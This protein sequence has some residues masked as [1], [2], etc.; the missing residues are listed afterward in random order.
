MRLP[1]LSALVF[2][3]VLTSCAG[4]RESRLNPRNWF[5]RAQQAETMTL[6]V[7]PQDKRPLV[8]QVLTLKVEPFPGGAIIR[9]TGLPPSQGWWNAELVP[10]VQDDPATLVFAFRT[11][12]PV[13]PAPAGTQPSREITVA[14]S[15]SD[16]K[17]SGIRTITVQ[18]E[19]NALSSHR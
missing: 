9:A 3:M 5:G 2:A 4:F 14:T 13:V 19:T 8:A 6:Y 1:I 7:A 15:V 12:P 17:L 18:G 10:V 16:I 11:F